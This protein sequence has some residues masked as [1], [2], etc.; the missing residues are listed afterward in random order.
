MFLFSTENLNLAYNY[1]LVLRVNNGKT[2]N[3]LLTTTPVKDTC[4]VT[5]LFQGS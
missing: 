4:H 5:L 2:L 1:K 3:L